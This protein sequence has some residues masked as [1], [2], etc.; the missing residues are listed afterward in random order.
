MPGARPQ[1]IEF[2]A[3]DPQRARRFWEGLL[4][5]PLHERSAKQG[6]GWE[7][8]DK[9]VAVGVHER[10]RGPGDTASLA[11]FT[12][13][14]MN[15]ALARVRELGGSVV[16]P[17]ETA[18]SILPRLRGDA[19]RAGALATQ[20]LSQAGSRVAAGGRARLR[21]RISAAAERSPQSPSATTTGV[22]RWSLKRCGSIASLIRSAIG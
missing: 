5:E 13:D 7:T 6:S 11:Y 17:G 14:D 16:H 1:L 22:G 10:G 21:D 20:S 2:P 12:V 15:G 8:L 4:D 3:D 9:G 19:V 18:W